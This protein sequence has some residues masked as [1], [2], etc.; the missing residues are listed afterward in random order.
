MWTS[1]LAVRLEGAAL[2]RYR[3]TDRVDGVLY[4]LVVDEHSGRDLSDSVDTTD[5]PVEPSFGSTTP[6][7]GPSCTQTAGL[8][9]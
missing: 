8:H 3:A 6:C 7:P 9:H 1:P 5:A 4:A 2:D